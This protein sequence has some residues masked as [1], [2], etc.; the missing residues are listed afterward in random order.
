M[1]FLQTLV[2][3]MDRLIEIHWICV[4][5]KSPHNLLINRY[6]FDILSNIQKLH[7]SNNNPETK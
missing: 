7:T 4:T 1:V 5:S 6:P 3:A 2:I